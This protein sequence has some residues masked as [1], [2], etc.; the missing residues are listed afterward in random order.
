M[1]QDNQDVLL[2]ISQF[3]QSFPRYIKKN[4]KL[5]S[6]YFPSQRKM[7]LS[8]NKQICQFGK[9]VGWEYKYLDLEKE[10]AEIKNLMTH[11]LYFRDG[12]WF[13]VIARIL[14]LGK[15]FEQEEDCKVVQIESDV[16]LFRNF[17][18]DKFKSISER[19]A[20][21]LHSSNQGVASILFINTIE[22]FKIIEREFI[23][24]MKTDGNINDMEILH[25]IYVSF[26]NQVRVLPTGSQCLHLRSE[27][28]DAHESRAISSNFEVFQGS[29]DD[30]SY[31]L[32]LFGWD[33]RN[34]KG[35]RLTYSENRGQFIIPRKVKLRAG[36]GRIE[37]L[38]QICKNSFSLFNLHVHSKDAHLFSERGMVR[39]VKRVNYQD[40]TK[41]RMDFTF[42][43]IRRKWKFLRDPIL[44]RVSRILEKV[45]NLTR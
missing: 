16:R 28:I 10:Y 20:F 21:P 9:I 1:T 6:K 40:K 30:L 26:P 39:R 23:K 32:F 7:I 25:N 27:D 41:P 29:F 4:L 22:G 33:L 45:D 15:I 37:V 2:V 19:L 31:G 24:G 18:F 5:I 8:D 44:R 3:G 13:K 36:N 17:P 35:R 34:N 43:V 14:A 42:G 38:C 11:D 12:Y